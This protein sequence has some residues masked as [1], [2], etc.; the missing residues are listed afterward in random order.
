MTHSPTLFDQPITAGT[1]RKQDPWSSREAAKRTRPKK[2]QDATL[3]AL[4]A[5]GGTGTLDD[6]CAALPGKLRNALSRRLTDLEADGKIAKTGRF[7]EG[8]YGRP[9]AVWQVR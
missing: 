5:N 3:A 1:S 7:V 9:L 4:V 8:V 6:V 2:D